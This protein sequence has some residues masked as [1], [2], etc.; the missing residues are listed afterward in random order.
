[1]QEGFEVVATGVG[2]DCGDLV[3]GGTCIET[4]VGGEAPGPTCTH[5]D[6]A[7]TNAFAGGFS[8]DAATGNINICLYG[9]IAT[10]NCVS[11]GYSGCD[12]GEF[13]GVRCVP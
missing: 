11:E 3:E 1:M 7:C 9:E 8:C 6:E 12:S 2:I 10:F 5:P 13:F 4:P